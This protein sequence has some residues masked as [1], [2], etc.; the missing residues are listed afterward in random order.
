MRRPQIRNRECKWKEKMETEMW[1][2]LDNNL[3]GEENNPIKL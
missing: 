3:I 2:G 1:K